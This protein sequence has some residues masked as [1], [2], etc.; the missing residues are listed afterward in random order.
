MAISAVHVAAA[1]AIYPDSLRS[2]WDA[3]VVNAI[4]RDPSL[5]VLRGVGFWYVTAGF[6]VAMLGA[7]VRWGELR[8]GPVPRW[9]GAGLLA[10]AAWGVALMPKSGFWAF[11]VPALLALRRPRPATP[12]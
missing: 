2:T 4:E 11:G 12:T 7:I 1:P 9:F 8:Y 10:F 3:G 6:A 5:V